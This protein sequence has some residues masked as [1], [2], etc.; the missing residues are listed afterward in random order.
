MFNL[1]SGPWARFQAKGQH[2]QSVGILRSIR[3]DELLLMLG[4]R[5]A[6][7]VRSNMY[8]KHEISIEEHQAW[9]AKINQCADQC[10]L[11]YER[12]GTP[13]GVVGINSI[14][15]MDQHAFWA[16]Y[17]APDAPRGTGTFMEFL[18]L[19]Y[20]F[21]V[22]SL[23]KLSCEVLGF[24]SSVIKLHQK[25][26]FVIEGVFRA[27]HKIDDQ[28]VDVYRL[29]IMNTEWREVRPKLQA[30]IEKLNRK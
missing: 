22:L 9:W 14:N 8:T 3:D 7:G 28:F 2:M 15:T 25:F 12:A 4:W 1:T 16:F 10:Y 29:G 27:H 20:I 19:D 26:G 18:A 13:L 17:A 24:N 6:P 11:M 5:N 21:E 23:H 30:K